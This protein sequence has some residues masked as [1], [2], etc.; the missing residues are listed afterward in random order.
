VVRQVLS[1]PAREAR[2]RRRLAERI[3][4]VVRD[5]RPGNP[6]AARAGA[7][8]EP[9]I[10]LVAAVVRSSLPLPADGA[11]AVRAWLR[12]GPTEDPEDDLYI[13]EERL[14]MHGRRRAAREI[15]AGRIAAAPW[16]EPRARRSE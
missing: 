4:R 7:G 6:E 8:L 3:E 12:D 2:A 14:G 5:A 15:A 9:R 11:R 1:A 16:P 10:L 13:V